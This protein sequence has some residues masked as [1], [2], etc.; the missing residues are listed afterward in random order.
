MVQCVLH[1]AGG[2]VLPA[3]Q[4]AMAGSG[5]EVVE[6]MSSFSLVLK[7]GSNQK[8]PF[9]SVCE[10]MGH[11]RFNSSVGCC[12]DCAAA[13]RTSTRCQAVDVL[14]PASTCTRGS[15]TCGA[16]RTTA[17]R[18]HCTCGAAAELWRRACKAGRQSASG[19]DVLLLHV[20]RWL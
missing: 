16:L 10:V 17:W 2:A 6:E 18:T 8:K 5:S 1:T 12:A 9:P 20:T 4:S 3:L 15:T 7:P 13:M 19:L 14:M 11:V